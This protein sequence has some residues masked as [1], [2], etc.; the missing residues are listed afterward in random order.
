MYKGLAI[1]NVE[2][3]LRIC[4]R[5]NSLVLRFTRFLINRPLIGKSVHAH[6]YFK[7]FLTCADRLEV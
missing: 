2:F 1:V 5:P 6:G 7:V 3:G 4:N